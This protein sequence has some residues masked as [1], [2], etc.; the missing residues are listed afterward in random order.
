MILADDN[1]GTIIE[2]VARGRGIFDNIRKFLRFLLSS[3]MG[4]VITVFFGVVLASFLGLAADE[5]GLAVPL[6]ATQILWINLV[7]DSGPAL[8]M[9]VDPDDGASW[10]GRLGIRRRR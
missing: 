8:A 1:Y 5:G 10:P 3:N 7:T 9:G 6:L 2:A 4:E